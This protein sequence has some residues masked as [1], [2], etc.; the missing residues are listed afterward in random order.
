[1]DHPKKLLHVVWA[2]AC[3]RIALI[4]GVFSLAL[5]S[6]L[7]VNTVYLHR[8]LGNGKVRLVEARELAPLKPPCA[9][10]RK[11]TTSNKR[12]A[13][14]TSTCVKITS[15]AKNSPTGVPGACWLVPQCSSAHS[16]SPATCAARL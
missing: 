10:I 12:S 5:A 3:S 6:L 8:G 1:M 2:Q 11:T 15:G 16:N 4:A 7:V 9:K 14:S 13:V